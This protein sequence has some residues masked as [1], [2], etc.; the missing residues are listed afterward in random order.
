MRASLSRCVHDGWLSSSITH[1]ARSIPSQLRGRRTGDVLVSAGTITTPIKT[2]S[3][4]GEMQTILEMIAHTTARLRTACPAK[5]YSG[6]GCGMTPIA[7]SQSKC[8]GERA[9]FQLITTS[10]RVPTKPK[11]L[12]VIGIITAIIPCRTPPRQYYS[13][14]PLVLPYRHQRECFWCFGLTLTT[15]EF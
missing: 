3:E 8:G 5:W 7:R 13:R 10:D 9:T 6:A 12:T 15:F 1:A 2:I 14:T 4:T 11:P